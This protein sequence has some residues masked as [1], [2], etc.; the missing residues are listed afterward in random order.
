MKRS[1]I[2]PISS[3]VRRRKPKTKG[4]GSESSLQRK[5]IIKEVRESSKI[6]NKII[7]ECK[8]KTA[9]FVEHY[10]MPSVLNGYNP[11]VKI[12]LYS[13]E[14]ENFE[15]HLVDPEDAEMLNEFNFD[16]LG[17]INIPAL[18]K[19]DDNLFLQQEEEEEKFEA[20]L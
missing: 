20:F 12:P 6:N 7:N 19:F 4:I 15:P 2:V 13:I 5:E 8:K 9:G 10:P 18:E 11:D 17:E 1:K 3:S 16:E 14:Q